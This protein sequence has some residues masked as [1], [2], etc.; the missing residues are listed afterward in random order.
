MSRRF[1]DRGASRPRMSRDPLP[2]VLL[3]EVRALG[4]PVSLSCPACVHNA[5]VPVSVFD[6]FPDDLDVA[7]IGHAARCTS[8]GRRGGAGA[9]PHHRLWV[10]HL[11]QTGQRHRLPYWSP[12]MREAE[13]EAVLA[14][15]AARARVTQRR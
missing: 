10:A 2:P 15:F 12:F 13:D 8:C 14:D 7:E 6:G 5:V 9:H 4:F 1:S 11:R 3:G